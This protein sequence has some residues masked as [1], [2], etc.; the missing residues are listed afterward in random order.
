M[1][2]SK[3]VLVQAGQILLVLL[4]LP[5]YIVA[6]LLLLLFLAYIRVLELLFR[7]TK[8]GG[9]MFFPT[10]IYPWTRTLEDN[11]LKIRTELDVLLADLDQVPNYQD[12]AESQRT[13]TQDDK[14]KAVIFNVMGTRVEENCR[15]CPETA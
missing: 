6:V 13:L 4:L 14:W 7:F 11:W 2:Q 15:A 9:Q 10:E 12:V 1:S 8:H 5:V 3:S